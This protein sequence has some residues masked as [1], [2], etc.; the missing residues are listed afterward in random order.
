MEVV[1][2]GNFGVVHKAVWR[3]TIVAAKILNIYCGSE[4]VLKEIEMCR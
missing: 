1:G 3:G 4:A 2:E